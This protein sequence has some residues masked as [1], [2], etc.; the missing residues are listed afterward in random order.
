MTEKYSDL[1]LDEI[2]GAC[3]KVYPESV[4]DLAGALGMHLIEHGWPGHIVRRHYDFSFFDGMGT[5]S[6]LSLDGRT[7]DLSGK[8]EDQALQQLVQDGYTHFWSSH[9]STSMDATFSVKPIDPKQ[10]AVLDALLG[11]IDQH[12]HLQAAT[13]SVSATGPRARARM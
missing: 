13:P 8:N 2:L 11:H 9:R 7:V 12:L 6:F 3:H 10:R 4:D 1:G 5:H